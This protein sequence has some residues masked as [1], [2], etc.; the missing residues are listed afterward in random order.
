MQKCIFLQRFPSFPLKLQCKVDVCLFLRRTEGR[1]VGIELHNEIIHSHY[2][3][4]GM[5][6][7]DTYQKSTYLDGFYNIVPFSAPIQK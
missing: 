5:T 2:F 1:F 3:F 6:M 7:I 4:F